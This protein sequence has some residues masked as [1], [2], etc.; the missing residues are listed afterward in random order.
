M[1]GFWVE[2]YTS[3]I[4]SGHLLEVCQSKAH[5]V[6]FHLNL[7]RQNER[8]TGYIVNFQLD[9]DFVALPNSNFPHIAAGICI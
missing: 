1:F 9:P 4:H 8:I 3:S 7:S 5:Y 6:P 2:S